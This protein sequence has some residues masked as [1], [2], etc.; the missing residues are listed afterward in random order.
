MLRFSSMGIVS[1]AISW[2]KK[3]ET[4]QHFLFS[5]PLDI[6]KSL[7]WW[8]FQTILLHNM[9]FY[10]CIHP[11]HFSGLVII[12]SSDYYTFLSSEQLLNVFMGN[13]LYFIKYYCNFF[14]SLTSAFILASFLLFLQDYPLL[15]SS[16]RS[17]TTITTT[18]SAT[19]PSTS[20]Y[21]PISWTPSPLPSVT[22]VTQSD[23]QCYEK[24][25][26]FC[27]HKSGTWCQKEKNIYTYLYIW[28]CMQMQF[29]KKW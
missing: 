5:S 23:H 22:A 28:M 19:S 25:N 26:H 8:Y 16:S 6:L 4:T 14:Y 7:N 18:A 1:V 29:F 24:K 20:T 12:R 9:L 3:W 15:S 13:L 10:I 27:Q 21:T 2:C 11:T 17:T